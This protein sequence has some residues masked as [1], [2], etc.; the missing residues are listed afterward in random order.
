MPRPRR[1]I[2]PLLLTCSLLAPLVFGHSSHAMETKELHMTPIQAIILG[3]VEGLT[4]F[5]PVSSTGHLILTE[6]ALGLAKTPEIKQAAD[7]YTIVI[8]VGAILAVLGVYHHQIKLILLGLIGKSAEGLRL[9]RNIVTAFIPAAIVGLLLVDLIKQY[10]FGLWPVTFAWFVGGV[11]LM[12]WGKNSKDSEEQA[13]CGLE[14]LTV[15]QALVIGVLQT[16]AVWP[17]T[18]RSLVT[19]LGGRLVGLN[20]KD[21]VLFSFLLGMVTLGA[22]TSYDLLKEGALMV[23]MFGI[24]NLLIGI[25]AAW[26]SAWLAVKGMVGY[27]KK[28]GLGVFGIYRVL[29][30]ITSAILLLTG[31]LTA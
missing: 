29:L 31:V 22:S 24:S 13:G 6:H 23:E 27:L 3:V 30:A 15:K 16:V 9:F 2:A 19:I 12:I 5:L 18:S 8:Q 14:N 10:L 7:A 21:S 11:A 17:G 1:L 28:H 20:L 25:I 4:E 26:G